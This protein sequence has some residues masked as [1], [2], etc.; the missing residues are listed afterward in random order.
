MTLRTLTHFGE[1]QEI[2]I[3]IGHGGKDHKGDTC[4]CG[5]GFNK[6]L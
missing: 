2:I 4:L 1:L 3:A 5:S 6:S